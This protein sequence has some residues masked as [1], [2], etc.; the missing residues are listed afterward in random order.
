MT[1][2]SALRYAVTS[3]NVDIAYAVVGEGRPVVYA[4]RFANP[5]IDLTL[6]SPRWM[7]QFEPLQHRALV[8]FDWRGLGASG[9]STD[10][11]TAEGFRLDLAAVID[12][13]G[14]EP[15][16]LV[17]RGAPIDLALEF[18][19]KHPE[20]VRRLVLDATPAGLDPEGRFAGVLQAAASSDWSL[21]AE[22]VALLLYGF[23]DSDLAREVH[24]RLATSLDRDRWRELL[25]A[26][27]AFGDP[28]ARTVELASQVQAPTLN[29]PAT[30]CF[31]LV[32]CP[33]VRAK[34][35][36]DLLPGSRL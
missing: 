11:F 23:I 14:S 13:V 29:V 18:A 24:L 17:A 8:L 22:L 28:E 25:A 9:V 26:T 10:G 1:Q 4:G 34:P 32:Q 20:R 16:D 2:A 21:S 6:A 35:V 5:G 27:S 30:G 15:V 19:A 7:K 36:Q 33:K 3:D 31:C 12:A